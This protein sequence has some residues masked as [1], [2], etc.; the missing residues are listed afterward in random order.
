MK[1]FACRY[2][3]MTLPVLQLM[4]FLKT[5]Y[6]QG[7]FAHYTSLPSLM[8]ILIIKLPS[9]HLLAAVIASLPSYSGL[10][11]VK[12]DKESVGVRWDEFV[13]L[14]D[15]NIIRDSGFFSVLKDPLRTLVLVLAAYNHL[16][17][18]SSL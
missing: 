13:M 18:L 16:L 7:H 2:I 17:N 8:Y 6:T 15:N 11:L 5:P 10:R 1:L 14:R 4:I 12:L 9:N 3:K